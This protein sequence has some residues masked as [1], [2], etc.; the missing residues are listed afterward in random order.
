[1]SP[2]I[3]AFIKTYWEVIKEDFWN[4]VK[5]FESSCGL[6]NGCNSSFIVLIPKKKDPIGFSD[7]RPI[8]LIGCVYKVI[9]KLLATRLAKVI[10]SVIGPNQ[11]AFI[12]GW[13]IL[14]GCLIASEIIRMAA[15]ENHKLLLFKVDFKKAFNTINWNFLLSIMTQ[16][17]FD[18]DVEGDKLSCWKAKTLSIGGRLILIKSILG[19][20]PEI[21]SPL[22]KAPQKVINISNPVSRADSYGFKESQ[23]G[24]VLVSSGSNTLFWKDPWCRSAVRLMDF[25]RVLALK[26]HKDCNISERWSLMN[27]AWGWNWCWRFPPRGRANDD[28]ASLLSYI[29]SLPPLVEERD[30]WQWAL[31]GSGSYKVCIMSKRIQNLYL[32]NHSI[33]NHHYWNSWIPRKSC[34][35]LWPVLSMSGTS[36]TWI[37]ALSYVRVSYPFGGKFGVG[38]ILRNIDL[39]GGFS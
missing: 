14:D 36:K 37:I 30:K 9:S 3:I 25:P 31:D 4:C 29:G 7:Y 32:A 12:E 39:F 10:N 13:Q 6:S 11:S 19:R 18:E 15:L 1:M 24:F 17:G 22:F 28:L 21:N 33:A 23:R 8:S 26:T 2:F 38:G 35:N 34:W 16:I 20:L 27:N 5:L